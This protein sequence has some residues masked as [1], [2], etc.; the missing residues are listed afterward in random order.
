MSRLSI[1]T[2]TYRDGQVIKQGLIE[3]SCA[4]RAEE[5]GRGWCL[6]GQKRRFINVRDAV[7]VREEVVDESAVPM[8]KEKVG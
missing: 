5:L 4:E 6:E 8:K 2:M 1:Y 7:L 3:A